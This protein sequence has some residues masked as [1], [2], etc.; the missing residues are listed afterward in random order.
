MT[1]LQA[2]ENEEESSFNDRAD[3]TL[4]GTFVNMTAP[5]QPRRE[6]GRG[7]TEEA[8]MGLFDVARGAAAAFSRTAFP[9]RGAANASQAQSM[10][11]PAGHVRNVSSG[12]SDTASITSERERVRKRDYV[13]NAVTG[14]LASGLGWVLGKSPIALFSRFLLTFLRSDACQ[15]ADP[16]MM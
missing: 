16:A 1:A 3:R 4:P 6:V 12:G 15:S 7:A 9:L 10:G 5:V 2:S 13:A 11:P 8:P 14:G